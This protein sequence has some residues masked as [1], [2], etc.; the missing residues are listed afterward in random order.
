MDE[1][2]QKLSSART[3]LILD[4]PFLGALVLRLPL[5]AA[6]PDWCKT[7]A[8]DARKLYYN[9]SYILQ[10]DNDELQFVLTHE[11]LHCGLLH[12]V[13]RGS[14][15]QHLWDLACD[16]AINPI[17]KSEG[18]KHPP[19]ALFFHEYKGLSAE[20][21]YPM[22]DDSHNDMETMDQHLYDQGEGGQSDDKPKDKGDG[23]HESQ[24]RERSGEQDDGE[25]KKQQQDPELNTTTDASPRESSGG[26]AAQPEPLSAQQKEDLATQWQQRLAGAAQQAM[27]AGR[28]SQ[29]MA[30][31]V[32]HLLQ[33]RLSWRAL[34]AQHMNY[35]A[36]DDYSYQRPSSRRDDAAIFPSLRNQQ[37]S[38][39]AI[40]D[41]SGSISDQQLTE[42][43]S[44]IDSIKAQ[45]RAR[46]I[47]HACDA[48]LATDGPWVF[49]PWEQCTL[50]ETLGGGGGTDFR[51][52][53]EWLE[54]QDLAADVT[55]FFTDADGEFPKYEPHFP[56]IWLVKGQKPVP[57]GARIQ[58]N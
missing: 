5:V 54:Q 55:I 28:L 14:R 1:V 51:P 52:A 24:Q 33:P 11:A 47:I 50:P 39:C 40:V 34:L 29:E 17:L 31:L 26:L 12:F 37:V 42:F 49:E 38:V 35:L 30:R 53:F 19:N 15:T 43:I 7:T 25:Q 27:Q 46:V 10:L 41:T 20:E 9:R 18:L 36:R 57:F 16:F 4:K 6:N 44:E 21:I 2:E 3:Q 48:Q 45:I 22:L 56:V 23:E 8:T 32:D 13:R 58:L